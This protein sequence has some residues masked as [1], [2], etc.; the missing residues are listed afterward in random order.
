M[1]PAGGPDASLQLAG[2][3]AALASHRLGLPVGVIPEF[4]P[5]FSL[6]ALLV[7]IAPS[8]QAPQ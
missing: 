2:T 6:P 1:S 7:H 3:R 5:F 4:V 8:A